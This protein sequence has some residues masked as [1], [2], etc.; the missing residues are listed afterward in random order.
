ME[1]K[2]TYLANE[3]AKCFNEIQ[4]IKKL[5]TSKNSDWSMYKIWLASGRKQ[6]AGKHNT[7]KRK[8][9]NRR[10]D[11]ENKGLVLEIW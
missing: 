8:H 9:P 1:E 11:I 4:Q 3:S 7:L 6:T 10:G 5:H 2:H